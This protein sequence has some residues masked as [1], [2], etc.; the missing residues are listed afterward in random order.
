MRPPFGRFTIGAH[1]PDGAR[2]R[3]NATKGQFSYLLPGGTEVDYNDIVFT[4]R[5]YIYVEGILPDEVR[6]KLVEK[7]RERDLNIVF[8]DALYAHEKASSETPKAFISHDSRDK[9]EIARPIATTLRSMRCPVWYDE[10][11]LEVGQSL[12]ESI[13]HGLKISRKCI[14]VLTPNFLSKG[15]WPKREYEA[16]FTRELIEAQNLILPVWSQVSQREVF[17][18]S[19]ILAD[20]WGLSWDQLG[21]KE[22]CRR[23]FVNLNR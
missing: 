15:G 2:F 23:L 3:A 14:F 11:S 6:A 4:G 12:R 5:L 17:D 10:F 9:D 1:T 18:F 8:R 20:R 21:E 7:A 22:V 16:V 13:E 19:P